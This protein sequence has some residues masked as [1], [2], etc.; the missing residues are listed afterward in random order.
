MNTNYK[1]HDLDAKAFYI[2][3]FTD[4][5]TNDQMIK[6]GVSRNPKSRR[7]QLSYRNKV[8]FTILETF[9][10]SRDDYAHGLENRVKEHFSH[11][12][13]VSLKEGFNEVIPFSEEN[14]T[15]ILSIVEEYRLTRQ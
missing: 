5:V 11:D 7:T 9:P 13:K 12:N 15:K 8:K 2:M 3:T 1:Q 10:F 4:K 14:I 6:I